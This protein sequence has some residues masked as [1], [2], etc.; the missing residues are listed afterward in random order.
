MTYTEASRH[1]AQ[2]NLSGAWRGHK[3]LSDGKLARWVQDPLGR[4][5]FIKAS[6]SNAFM[7]HYP[8]KSFKVTFTYC[9]KIYGTD[10]WHK[11]KLLEE[12]IC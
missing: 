10:E 5:G 3:E 2:Y 4:I 6:R 1:N 9:L 12:S 11:F 8:V 7:V